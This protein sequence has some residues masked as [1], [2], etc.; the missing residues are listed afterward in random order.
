MN[1]AT[2]PYT[3]AA[4]TK[5]TRRITMHKKT[6]VYPGKTLLNQGKNPTILCYRVKR[7]SPTPCVKIM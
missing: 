1:N 5:I 4:V 7:R 2:I 3:I 6:I